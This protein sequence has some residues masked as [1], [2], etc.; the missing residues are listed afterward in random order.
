MRDHANYILY[1]WTKLYISLNNILTASKFTFNNKKQTTKHTRACQWMFQT[2][3]STL[4]TWR[5]MLVTPLYLHTVPPLCLSQEN[6][7]PLKGDQ[8]WP[9]RDTKFFFFFFLLRLSRN[10]LKRYHAIISQFIARQI[11]TYHMV[12][13]EKLE[14]C[15]HVERELE[16]ILRK[17]KIWLLMWKRFVSV[18]YA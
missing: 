15:M 11:A 16:I 2:G 5:T 6:N 14:S 1:S 7:P 10:K 18:V 17:G 3:T 13:K 4:Q 8:M 9:V 12:M